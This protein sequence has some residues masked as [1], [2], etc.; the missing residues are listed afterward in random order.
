MGMTCLFQSREHD[1]PQPFVARP[2]RTATSP[3][4]RLPYGMRGH[5]QWWLGYW[6]VELGGEHDTIHDTEH[7]RDELLK[8]TYGVWDH[9]KNRCPHRQEAQNWALEWMQFLPAKRE[10]RRYVG[11]MC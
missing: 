8:I 7:L 6:W 11:R 9:I 1:T 4:T 3:A 2:G 10:S 5:E